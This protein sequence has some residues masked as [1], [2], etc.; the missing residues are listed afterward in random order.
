ML[1]VAPSRDL[2]VPFEVAAIDLAPAWYAIESEARVDG[3]RVWRF[4]GQPF[5]VPWPRTEIRRG[6]IDVG[7]PVAIGAKRFVVERLELGGDSASVVWREQDDRARAGARVGAREGRGA[8][9]LILADGATLDLLP[10]AV[11]SL[12]PEF[13]SPAGERRSVSYPLRRSV[14]SVAVRIR[15]SQKE[16]SEPLVISLP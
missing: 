16:Q 6:T 3:G 14:S 13:R 15:L 4:S 1:D 10:L 7:R 11:S 5:T 8:E 9:V 12:R 2:F